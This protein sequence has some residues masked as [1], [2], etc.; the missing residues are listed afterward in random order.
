MTQKLTP[1]ERQ[2]ILKKLKHGPT[3]DR[4]SL[5]QHALRVYEEV[6]KKRKAK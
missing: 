5:A 2:A 3:L 4:E 6:L 1:S